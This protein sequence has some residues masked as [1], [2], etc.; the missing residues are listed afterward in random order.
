[1]LFSSLPSI[2]SV[3]TSSAFSSPYADILES[4]EFPILNVLNLQIVGFSEVYKS[5]IKSRR[6][7]MYQNIK[8]CWLCESLYL[9]GLLRGQFGDSLASAGY[10][11]II[12]RGRIYAVT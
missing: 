6:K 3:S 8:R 9:C 4:Y 7:A 2:F 12:L 5:K 1:M 10:E 11:L